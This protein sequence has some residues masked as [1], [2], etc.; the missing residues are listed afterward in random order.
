MGTLSL[1]LCLAVCI[2]AL[3]GAGAQEQTT[4][5]SGIEAPCDGDDCPRHKKSAT[6]VPSF[7]KT[8]TT[9]TTHRTTP[10]TTT[11]P[12]NHTTT[13]PA[14]HTTTQHTTPH[15][16]THPA[17]HTTTHSANHTTTH[18]TT[19]HTTT[20]HTTVHTTPHLTTAAPPVPPDVGVGNYS[21]RNGSDICLRV[22]SGLQIWVR[23][24]NR[25]KAQ[26]WGAFAVQPNHT[27][28][29]GNC[30]D[31]SATMELTFAQ[32]YLHF[33]FVKNKTQNSVYLHVV[34]A[35]LSLEFPGAPQRQFAVRNA[36]LRA[37]EAQLGHSYQ[38]QNRSLA[39]GPAFH[40][41]AL[42]ERLQAFALHGGGFGE[43]ELCPEDQHSALVPII[44]G[45]VLLV[46]ILIIVIA[47]LVGRRKARGG[48]QTL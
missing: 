8:T 1:L 26:V 16:T 42:H 5:G 4:P 45:V 17:N 41:D 32:G 34:R 38:C 36:S 6:L 3:P 30:S 2:S 48:Y 20:H 10:H 25:S 46:M 47:Y 29:S 35:N 37:F 9:T 23:Y 19:P 12:A 22:Q 7:T 31:D 43:A 15:T 11:H 21:V 40:L 44:I 13:H 27:K 14:N 24:E 28:V 39:L 33:T 18:H